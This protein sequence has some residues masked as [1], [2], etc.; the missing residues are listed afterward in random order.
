MRMCQDFCTRFRENKLWLHFSDT[1]RIGMPNLSALAARSLQ[2][3]FPSGSSKLCSQSAHTSRKHTHTET[4]KMFSRDRH[5]IPRATGHLR[6]T[7]LSGMLGISHAR[8]Q[9]VYQDGVEF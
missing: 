8:R 1:K 6:D 7:M 5:L 9:A 2:R 3:C 4:P